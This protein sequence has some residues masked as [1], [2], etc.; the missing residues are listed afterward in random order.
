MEE[1]PARMENVAPR[2][3]G[4]GSVRKVAEQ[5]RRKPVNSDVCSLELPSW[6]PAWASLNDGL[7]P[8]K[9][10]NLPQVV[11]CY[12]VGHSNRKGHPGHSGRRSTL[13]G[14]S[15]NPS[16]HTRLLEDTSLCSFAC[17]PIPRPLLTS[18]V[19]LKIENVLLG[20]WKENDL[21]FVLVDKSR[22]IY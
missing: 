7:W 17:R 21:R 20:W 18:Q 19:F 11:F 15:E 16:L 4:L 1:G 9:W 22:S 2:Q 13:L 8:R 5:A 6:I 12:G 3:L 14:F 10:N